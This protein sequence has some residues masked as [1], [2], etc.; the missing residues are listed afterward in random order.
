[1]PRFYY[2]N[3]TRAMKNN[4][5]LY[6]EGYNQWKKK[7]LQLAKEYGFEHIVTD[8]FLGRRRLLGFTKDAQGRSLRDVAG[9]G[10]PWRLIT[11]NKGVR[12]LV[13]PRKNTKLG[14]AI[15]AQVEGVGTYPDVLSLFEGIQ[16]EIDNLPGLVIGESGAILE[17]HRQ[18][19]IWS[20]DWVEITGSEYHKYAE[21][22]K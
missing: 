15:L 13:V 8:E 4:V 7:G 10:T 12:E 1:M 20:A 9:T 21:E 22:M 17:Y 5:K 19:A 14:K 11:S 2:K 3:T 16:T 6:L 18:P